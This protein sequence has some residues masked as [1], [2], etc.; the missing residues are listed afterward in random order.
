[1]KRI[2]FILA[3]IVG[4]VAATLGIVMF[5]ARGNAQDEGGGRQGPRVAG[6]PAPGTKLSIEELRKRW[7]DVTVGRKLKPKAWPNNAKTAVTFAFDVNGTGAW[8]ATLDI[9]ENR[10]AESE[11]GQYEGVPRIL[12]MMKK[13]DIPATFYVPAVTVIFY[14]QTLKGIVDN[15]PRNDVALHGWMHENHIL[16]SEPEARRL[17]KQAS[18][19]L[20]KETGKRPVGINFPGA[21]P[22]KASMRLAKELGL[23][24]DGSM[25]GGDDAYEINLDGKPSGLVEIPIKWILNDTM[26]FGQRGALPSPEAMF[27]VWTDEFDVAYEEGS[28]ANFTMHPTNGGHRSVMP[29]LERFI[30]HIKSKGNVWIAS[31]AEVAAYVKKNVLDASSH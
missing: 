22:G 11:Y 21:R 30:Q 20:T 26:Y 17:L 5:E 28:L 6:D 7:F 3:F 4:A 13:Y 15:N 23:L 29:H 12:A 24:Y 1:M 10:K 19:Y 16:V 18:D 25:M 14:P 9:P 27:K 8:A 31:R 2:G